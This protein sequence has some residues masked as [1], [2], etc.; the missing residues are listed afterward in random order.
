MAWACDQSNNVSKQL[1]LIR[2]N[3][4][5][6]S[7][8][9]NQRNGLTRVTYWT[10]KFDGTGSG[11]NFFIII[12]FINGIALKFINEI[13]NS[14]LTRIFSQINCFRSLEHCVVAKFSLIVLFDQS[15]RSI[16]CVFYFV[17]VKTQCNCVPKYHWLLQLFTP[18]RRIANWCIANVILKYVNRDYP[19]GVNTRYEPQNQCV[20]TCTCKWVQAPSPDQTVEFLDFA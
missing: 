2:S 19:I 18:N 15:L 16:S 5:Y 3:D 6:P 14:P 1:K 8:D 11:I 4:F 9:E 17:V 10:F 13:L 12:S 20:P 7:I